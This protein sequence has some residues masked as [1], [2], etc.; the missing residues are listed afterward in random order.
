MFAFVETGG[1]F[2][3]LILI[4]ALVNTMLVIRKAIQLGAGKP[5][6]SSMF[7]NGL[8]AILFWGV[9]CA[10][11]GFLGQYTGIYNAMG[12]ISKATELS[13]AV[14]ARGFGQ[15][16][17]TTLMGLNVLVLSAVAWF[18][19]QSLY[20]RMKRDQERGHPTP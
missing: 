6:P 1:P 11:L 17:T 7:E 10:V 3:W 9:I 15:S 8:N 18:V 2:G 4:L 19:L 5:L 16:F 13:P 12:A 14:I 20:Q